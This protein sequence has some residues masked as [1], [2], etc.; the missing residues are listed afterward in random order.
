MSDFDP[1]ALF[2]IAHESLGTLLWLLLGLA[3]L[4][5]AGIVASALKLQRAGRP[6]TRPVIAA[7]VL[8]LAATAAAVFAVPGWTLAG[9]GALGAAIDYAI[10][11]LF[12]LVPGATVGALIFMLAARRCAKR[13]AAAA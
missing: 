6:P 5:L 9:P 7:L 4:L 13:G 11:A 1:V 12:A 3:A 2:F 10:A 8:G